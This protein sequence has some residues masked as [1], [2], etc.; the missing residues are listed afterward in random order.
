MPRYERAGMESTLSFNG[1]EGMTPPLGQRELYAQEGVSRDGFYDSGAERT[2]DPY[3]ES[4]TTT[5]PQY[6]YDG[7]GGRRDVDVKG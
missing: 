4:T 1:S 6:H 7:E 2:Y 5:P 3:T